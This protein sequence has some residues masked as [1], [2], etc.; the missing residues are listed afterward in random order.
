MHKL[1]KQNRFIRSIPHFL[2]KCRFTTDHVEQRIPATSSPPCFTFMAAQI[3]LKKPSDV[4]IS[5][6]PDDVILFCFHYC[7]IK[8]YTYKL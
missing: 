2:A 3:H 6:A 4:R 7:Q 1:K 5:L 8:L